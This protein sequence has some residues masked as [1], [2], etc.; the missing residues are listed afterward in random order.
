VRVV[1]LLV[2]DD[3]PPLQPA[4]V[5]VVEMVV[6]SPTA[7]Q[8]VEHLLQALRHDVLHDADVA[9]A[10]LVTSPR[11]SGNPPGRSWWTAL[12]KLVVGAER[13]P[14]LQAVVRRRVADGAVDGEVAARVDGRLDDQRSAWGGRGRDARASVVAQ[15]WVAMGLDRGAGPASRTFTRFFQ[16]E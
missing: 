9:F 4:L 2:R 11:W 7:G 8:V 16:G 3:P 13:E 15:W 1:D 6:G 10:A 5:H 12:A 14:L